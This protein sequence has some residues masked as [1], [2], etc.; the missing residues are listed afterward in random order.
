MPFEAVQDQID[1]LL[2][3]ALDDLAK[4]VHTVVSSA[5]LAQHSGSEKD[6]KLVTLEHQAGVLCSLN[7]SSNCLDELKKVISEQARLIE[8]SL[9]TQNASGST[10]RPEGYCV[11][12]DV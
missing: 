12:I 2:L 8:L 4:Y 5:R 9:S 11:W 1:H 7:L 3:E 6:F 10:I